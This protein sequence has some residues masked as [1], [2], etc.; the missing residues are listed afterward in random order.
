MHLGNDVTWF[1][2]DTDASTPDGLSKAFRVGADVCLAGARKLN[3]D[4]ADTQ[5]L[6]CHAMELALKAFLA[7]RGMT[8]AKL[9]IKPYG[10]DLER[11]YHEAVKNGLSLSPMD[12]KVIQAIN[13]YHHKNLI[14]YEFDR[15]RTMPVCGGI[16]PVIDTIIKAV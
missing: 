7:K 9:R 12:E 15:T 13:E 10:H 16:F 6:T 14:R 5:I 8:A 11:L 4:L 3:S 2:P 1:L